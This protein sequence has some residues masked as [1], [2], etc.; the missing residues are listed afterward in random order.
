MRLNGL[1]KKNQ[2]SLLSILFAMKIT[3]PNSKR[4]LNDGENQPDEPCNKLIKI[5][6]EHRPIVQPLPS[7]SQNNDFVQTD[8]DININ[9][10]LSSINQAILCL[11]KKVSEILRKNRTK[12]SEQELSNTRI[13]SCLTTPEIEEFE[14]KLK[15]I[16]VSRSVTQ[17]CSNKKQTEDLQN[18][19]SD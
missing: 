5:E 17:I 14:A 2:A 9:N 4:P 6:V 11:N 10:Q 7:T 18:V 12:P 13:S 16:R 19:K 1:E 8:N 3:D 15:L